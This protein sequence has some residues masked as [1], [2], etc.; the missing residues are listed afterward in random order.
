MAASTTAMISWLP[1]LLLGRAHGL[2]L[3][4]GRLGVA[5]LGEIVERDQPAPSPQAGPRLI[6]A[7]LQEPGPELRPPL[8]LIDVLERREVAVL[9]G[10]LDLFA[11]PQHRTNRAV[12]ALVVA[13]HQQLERRQVPLLD[14]FD[15]LLVRLLARSRLRRCSPGRRLH[16]S[17]HDLHDD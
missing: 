1:G 15:E 12:E 2:L 17:P 3:R 16:L 13:A 10:V 14:P 8:E 11:R 7:D 4:D 5:P 9:H 6:D